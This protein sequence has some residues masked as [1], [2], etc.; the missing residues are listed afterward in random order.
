MTERKEVNVA[1]NVIAVHCRI[2]AVKHVLDGA[3][4]STVNVSYTML[5]ALQSLLLHRTFLY[6]AEVL[7]SSQPLDIAYGLVI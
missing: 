6:S 1:D 7:A 2:Y 3:R 4:S 5:R